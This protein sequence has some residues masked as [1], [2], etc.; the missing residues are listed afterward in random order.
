[1]YHVV[2]GGT[3]SLGRAVALIPRPWVYSE[4]VFLGETGKEEAVGGLWEITGPWNS[5]S[6]STGI[7]GRGF[8]CV[9]VCVS[10]SARVQKEGV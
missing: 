5:T 1:M 3:R 2:L 7:G 9:R 8:V 10:A 6:A 4:R